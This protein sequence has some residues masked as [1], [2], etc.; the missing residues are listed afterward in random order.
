MMVVQMMTFVLIGIL[1]LMVPDFLHK[2]WRVP[3][4]WIVLLWLG[5]D[6]CKVFLGVI[7]GGIADKGNVWITLFGG[8]I[9]QSFAVFLTSESAN[10]A[11]EEKEDYKLGW[12]LVATGIVFGLGTTTDGFIGG[13]FVKLMTEVER[14]LG[15]ECYE[16]LFAISVTVIAFGELIGNLYAGYVYEFV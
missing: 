16:E 8:L 7:G 5:W 9:C 11:M 1:F 6:I 10:A 15:H 13:P 14:L 2:Y 4:E 3:M 12:F